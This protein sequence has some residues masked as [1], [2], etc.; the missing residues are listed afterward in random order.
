[1]K[2]ILFVGHS[3]HARTGSSSFFLDLL[4]KRYSVT[5]ELIESEQPLTSTLLTNA[6][7]HDMV[8]VWQLDFLAPLFLSA[9]I[10]TAIA[11]MYD[12][13]ANHS[14]AHWNLLS[15]ASFVNFSRRLDVRVKSAGARSYL[16][17]YYVETVERDKAVSFETLR[18]FL[19]MRRPEDGINLKTAIDLLGGQIKSLHVHDAPDNPTSRALYDPSADIEHLKKL[20]VNV[21]FSRWGESSKD[22]ADAL[23]KANVFIAPRA[24]EGIGMALLE[25]MARGMVVLAAD[26]ATHDE[27]VS[28]WVNGIL[29]SRHSPGHAD[30]THARSLGES[31]WISAREGRK[32]WLMSQDAILDFLDEVQAPSKL[33]SI[34]GDPLEFAS[35][36]QK[37]FFLGQ[38]HYEGA[39]KQAALISS[40]IKRETVPNGTNI[41]IVM[42][43]Q[44]AMGPSVMLKAPLGDDCSDTSF[45]GIEIPRIGRQI[46]L[47]VSPEVAQSANICVA[48]LNLQDSS[49][50]MQSIELG[51]TINGGFLGIVRAQ[52][53]VGRASVIFNLPKSLLKLQNDVTIFLPC[54]QRDAAAEI[55]VSLLHIAFE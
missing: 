51:L 41:E 49:S 5:V 13:S 6:M 31:A 52:F 2:K 23:G 46:Q 4:R 26:D 37:S 22:Y 14:I 3:F 27:Y 33:K 36:L 7:Q 40:A 44:L 34:I 12:G 20:G 42:L 39:I 50:K 28:N 1:M 16:C 35:T 9:G 15:E 25:A 43:E 45:R 10:R 54:D 53:A 48:Y 18:A 17:R 38:S 29:F 8:F 11:P 47:R 30:L 32:R 24:S 19:W 55:G 21:T